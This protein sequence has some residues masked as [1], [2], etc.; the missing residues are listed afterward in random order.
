M[1]YFLKLFDITIPSGQSVT[2]S[3][4]S[5]TTLQAG[6]YIRVD[7]AQVGTTNPGSDLIVSFKY[8]SII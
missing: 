3:T 1:Q 6:D 7:I 4:E 5:P 8:R 2:Q